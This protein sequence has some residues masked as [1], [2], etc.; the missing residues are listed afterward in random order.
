ML[1]DILF[2]L[3]NFDPFGQKMLENEQIYV[4]GKESENL[5]KFVFKEN[6]FHTWKSSGFVPY[7]EF[8]NRMEAMSR[9]GMDVLINI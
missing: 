7:I 1:T 2:Y 9:S 5:S 6:I 8:S 4:K 3:S